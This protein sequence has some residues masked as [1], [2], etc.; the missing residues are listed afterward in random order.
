MTSRQ[1][2]VRATALATVMLAP[3]ALTAC[4]SKDDEAAASS[5]APAT[6]TTTTTATVAP[7][8]EAPTSEEAPT[9]E[10]A[11]T[12]DKPAE[13][14]PAPA[15]APEQQEAAP[16]P[17]PGGIDVN[18]IPVVEPIAGGQPGSEADVAQVRGIMEALNSGKTTHEVFRSLQNN[19]CTRVLQAN[20]QDGQLD[21]TEIP[22]VPV[23][24][25]PNYQ[26]SS[27][28]EITDVMVEG[29]E[30]SAQ[31]STVTG[32]ETRTGTVRFAR[33]GG[34]WKLCD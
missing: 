1:T 18:N 23:T 4:G 13:E 19:T 16:V 3:V 29:D 33:E 10:A 22:D 6:S 20:G 8:T 21:L 15:P 14:T 11:P 31:V 5:T 34:Q 9:T 17:V 25:L 12:E 2:F 27:I 24:M 32:G 26:P 28:G 7:T 30:M